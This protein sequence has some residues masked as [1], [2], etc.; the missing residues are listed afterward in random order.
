MK[1]T[2]LLLAVCLILVVI[3]VSPALAYTTPVQTGNVTDNIIWFGD[4]VTINSANVT[5]ANLQDILLAAATEH[6][7]IISDG[8]GTVAWI[9]ISFLLMALFV[10]IA[11][12]RK[13]PFM[14]IVAGL[15]LIEFAWDVWSMAHLWSILIALAGG[16]TFLRAF[17]KSHEEK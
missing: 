8:A 4:N 5:I 7:D 13:E 2:V 1:K 15:S 11:Y 16:Y 12:W 10:V 6:A 14:R 3:Y 17:I 9:V